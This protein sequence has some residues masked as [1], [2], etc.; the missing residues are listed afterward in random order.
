MEIKLKKYLENKRSSNLEYLRQQRI[1]DRASLENARNN[2]YS[3]LVERRTFYLK[4]YPNRTFSAMI[5]ELSLIHILKNELSA[6]IRQ[7]AFR[8]F[9]AD[10]EPDLCTAESRIMFLCISVKGER[11]CSFV[12]KFLILSGVYSAL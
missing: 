5:T 4:S 7:T 10:S 3:R 8:L 6:G 11:L 1:S 9:S 2:A 12:W